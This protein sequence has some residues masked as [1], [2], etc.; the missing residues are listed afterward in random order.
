M[1]RVDEFVNQ[2]KRQLV[3]SFGIKINLALRTFPTM[4][5]S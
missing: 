3:N 4:M 1:A 5:Q 2:F